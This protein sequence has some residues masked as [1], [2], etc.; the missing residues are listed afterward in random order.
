MK[1]LAQLQKL[2]L[3]GTAVAWKGIWKLQRELPRCNVFRADSSA[4]NHNWWPM[5]SLFYPA[6]GVFF[7]PQTAHLALFQLHRK[8]F[9]PSDDRDLLHLGLKQ[10]EGHVWQGGQNQAYG[11]ANCNSATN[12]P[13]DDGTATARAT[14][15]IDRTGI[16]WHVQW[17]DQWHHRVATQAGW[18]VEATLE[19]VVRRAGGH[20]VSRVAGRTSP[21]HRRGSGG[22]PSQRVLRQIHRRASHAGFGRGL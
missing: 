12:H 8:A 17:V 3:T 18:S 19:A 9:L 1:G 2:D 5:E 15:A 20:R 10:E 4:A 22:R 13:L 16:W 14:S 21:R 6:S 7:F 11:R